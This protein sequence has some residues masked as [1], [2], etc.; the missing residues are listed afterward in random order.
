MLQVIPMLIVLLKAG[1]EIAPQI[2]AAAEL[3]MS[4]FRSASQPTPDE[5]ARIALGLDQANSAL[6]QEALEVPKPA[7]LGAG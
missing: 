1:I 4:L 7:V 5:L 6:Q 3:E 2:I